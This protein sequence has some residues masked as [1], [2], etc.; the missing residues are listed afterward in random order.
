MFIYSDCGPIL[1][2]REFLRT[3]LPGIVPVGPVLSR[4]F[5]ARADE[6]EGAG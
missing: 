6:M 2:A 4:R 1:L 5:A 3:I